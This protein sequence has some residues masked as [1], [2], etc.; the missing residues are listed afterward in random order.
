MKH[1]LPGV[2]HFEKSPALV[3]GKKGKEVRSH[4]NI[5][6][7]DPSTPCNYALENGPC[8]FCGFW[9]RDPK[10]EGIIPFEKAVERIEGGRIE[11]LLGGSMFD[12]EQVPTRELVAML[13]LLA[14]TNAECV[15]LETRP[16]YITREKIELVRK[17]LGERTLE[18]AV[19]LETANDELREQLG[20]GY[21]IIDVEEAF[22]RIARSGAYPVAYILVGLDIS[23]QEA[24]DDFRNSIIAL[25]EMQK[26]I[27]VPIRVALETFYPVD[28]T[29][30][31]GEY[32][33]AGFI[34]GRIIEAKTTNDMTIFVATSSEGLCDH[35]LSAVKEHFDQFNLTQD[36]GHLKRVMEGIAK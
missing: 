29:H 11:H 9:S 14:A 35:P 3:R 18:I 19:G 21:T 6:L 27:G 7:I 13:R 36:V 25:G 12:E 30:R 2:I 32:L 16:E 4:R 15:L 23:K 10:I 31:K 33:D 22:L 34:A 20:K 8:T 17:I 1:R 26:R 28:E 5:L 24:I